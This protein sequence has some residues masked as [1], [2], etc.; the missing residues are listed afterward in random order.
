MVAFAGFGIELLN[1]PATANRMSHILTV[2]LNKHA[3]I[4][5]DGSYI[6]LT[7]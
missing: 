4:F 2:P 1:N 3:L 7:E 6:I 5:V